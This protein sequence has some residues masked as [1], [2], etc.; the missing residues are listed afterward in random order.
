MNRQ[1]NGWMKEVRLDEQTNQWVDEGGE[2]R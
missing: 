1:I 2:V